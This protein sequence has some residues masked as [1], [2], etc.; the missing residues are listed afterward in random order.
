M[1]ALQILQINTLDNIF[2]VMYTQRTMESTRVQ[3]FY[4]F[5]MLIY[6]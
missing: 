2:K 3:N 5:L 6:D 1:Q 4:F